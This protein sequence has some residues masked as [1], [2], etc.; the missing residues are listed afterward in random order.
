MLTAA[1][2]R[3]IN[4][5]AAGRFARGDHAD[6]DDA[7]LTEAVALQRAGDPPSV[8]AATLAAALLGRQVFAAAPLPTALLAM[9]CS[10][11]LDGAMLLAPQGVVAGMVKGLAAGDAPGSIARWLEDRAVPSSGG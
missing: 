11:S 1:D 10:L 5:V 9:H 6:V 3:F 2:L 7:A 8:R 4:A